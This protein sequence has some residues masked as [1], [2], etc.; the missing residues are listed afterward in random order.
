MSISD[1][2]KTIAKSALKAF[3]GKPIVTR[4]WDNDN[5]SFID[6]LTCLD[7]PERGVTSYSTIGLF[8]HSIGYSTNNIPIR[9]E[10]VGA[11]GSNFEKYSN[12]LASCA[13]NIINSNFS[14][15]PGAVFTNVIDF[16][17][18]NCTMKHI[19]FTSPFIW[20]SDLKTIDFEAT[21][22]TW[23]LAV[24]IS[25]QELQYYNQNGSDAL[26]SLFEDNEIDIFDLNRNS[27]I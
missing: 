20:G 14:C 25:E 23:L 22:V 16:Y 11:C 17:E 27:V 13:F 3:G 9:I 6:I 18:E 2:N 8:E 21:K 7:R 15:Y 19:F 4:Y 12:I 5:G 1:E 10:I 26:E 24:P